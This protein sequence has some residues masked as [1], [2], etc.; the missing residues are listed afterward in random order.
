MLHVMV[1]DT[2]EGFFM[3]FFFSIFLLYLMT[4]DF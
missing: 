1:L 4:F 3:S 2:R